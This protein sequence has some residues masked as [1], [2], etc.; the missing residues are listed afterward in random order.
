MF[1]DFAALLDRMPSKGVIDESFKDGPEG[2][3][4]FS[5][6]LPGQVIFGKKGSVFFKVQGHVK[7]KSH[8]ERTVA[9]EN[10]HGGFSSI[11]AC[12]RETGRR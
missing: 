1:K 5:L 12:F 2:L 6:F 8:R 4:E 10:A 9:H 11:V 3:D 7:P